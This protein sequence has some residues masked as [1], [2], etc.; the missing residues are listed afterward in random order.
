MILIFYDILPVHK[1]LPQLGQVFV[2]IAS[3]LPARPARPSPST[4]MASPEKVLRDAGFSSTSGSSDARLRRLEH[5]K[6]IETH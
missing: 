4:P 1:L 6:L 3:K 5:M 2:L